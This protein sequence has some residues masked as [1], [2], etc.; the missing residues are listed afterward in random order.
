[1]STHRQDGDRA[2][3]HRTVAAVQPVQPV[4]LDLPDLPATAHG[5][6]A[7]TA[8]VVPQADAI[9]ALADQ[10]VNATRAYDAAEAGSTAEQEAGKAIA[11]AAASLRAAAIEA[12][13][14]LDVAVDADMDPG[15]EDCG[16]V[17][18]G[19]GRIT[20]AVAG[21]FAILHGWANCGWLARGASADLDGSG[22]AC[23]GDSQ[24]GGWRTCDGDGQSSGRP[25]ARS[26]GDT[27]VLTGGEGS[28][29]E[30]DTD[31]QV[32][33]L[34]GISDLPAIETAIEIDDTVKAAANRLAER[35]QSEIDGADW[36]VEEP[37]AEDCW[38]ELAPRHDDGQDDGRIG[39]RAGSPWHGGCVV[40]IR[41]G[42]DYRLYLAG[43]SWESAWRTVSTE[44]SEQRIR[45]VQRDLN[46]NED[47]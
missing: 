19:R 8:T 1:M 13:D 11:A 39:I 34:L 21:R 42:D 31:I 2:D 45:E 40:V 41:Q 10:V 30:G 38:S 44:N 47:D 5:E 23:W 26:D 16:S 15:V 18:T 43:E 3:H 27:V 4:P 9:R 7:A 6:R 28:D 29:S 25:R 37:S 22:L 17:C 14:G 46:A 36:G 33:D 12:I 32:F 35:I 20:V 24:P